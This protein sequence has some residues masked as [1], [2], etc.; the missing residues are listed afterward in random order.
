MNM[1]TQEQIE[2]AIYHEE[3]SDELEKQELVWRI[4]MAELVEQNFFDDE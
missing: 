2:Q 1:Q 3:L 4:N